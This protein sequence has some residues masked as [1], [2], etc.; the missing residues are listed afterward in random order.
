LTAVTRDKQHSHL[1]RLLA[2]VYHAFAP[3]GR[4]DFS[5]ISD[6]LANPEQ[7]RGEFL[8]AASETFEAELGRI[9]QL[10]A[11]RSIPL[12]VLILPTRDAVAFAGRSVAR[13]GGE[14]VTSAAPTDQPTRDPSLPTRKAKAALDRLGI[15]YLD[16]TEILSLQPVEEVF[17]RFDGHLTPRGNQ[18]ARDALLAQARLDCG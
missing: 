13:A 1:R 8:S 18:L 11:E 14:A 9:A 17:F 2:N 16:P 4:F 6:D 15:P 5:Q 7:W 10:A 3:R 12:E